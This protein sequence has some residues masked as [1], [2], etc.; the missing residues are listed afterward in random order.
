MEQGLAQVLLLLGAAIASFLVCQRLRIP[1]SLAY[2]AVGVL[3]GPATLGPVVDGEAIRLFA[4]F[5]IV[6][7][8]FT[9]GLNYSLPQLQALRG[10]VLWLGTAQVGLTTLIVGAL[11]W[12][13][14]ADVVAAF[15]IGAIFAQSSTTMISKQLSEQAEENSPHGRLG[16]A[17]SVFQDVTAVPFIVVIPVLGTAVGAAAIAGLIGTSL[18]KAAVAMLLVFFVGRWLLRPLFRIVARQRSAEA[19]TLTV[20]FVSLGAG[21]VTDMLGLSLA[22][23][24][25]LAGMVLGETEFRHQVEA[26]IRPF[27]DVLLGLFFIGIGMLFDPAALPAVWAWAVAGTIVLLAS[28]TLLV[29]GLVRRAGLPIESAWRTGLI[30]SVG[31]EF[32]LALLAIGIASGALDGFKAQVAFTAVLF[33]FIL[34]PLLIRFSSPIA[35]ALTPRRLENAAEAPVVRVEAGHLEQ[36]VIICGYGRI[37]QSV[38]H[39]L[40]QQGIAWGAMDLDLAKVRQARKAGEPVF[41]GDA[42][43]P[44]MLESMGLD[45]ARLVVVSNDDTQASLRVLAHV[46]SRHPG[47]P[48]MVRTRDDS[49]H[50]ALL[51]GGATEV[52][53]ETL[54]AGLMI[55]T[56]VLDR[57]DVAPSRII[58]LVERQRAAHYP[59]LRARFAGEVDAVDHTEQLEPVSLPRGCQSCGKTLREL[60]LDDGTATAIVR[61]GERLLDPAADTVLAEG[62]TVVLRGP[63][64][65]VARASSRLQGR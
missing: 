19:F 25:F 37:G 55:A 36:H 22:F 14:G 11:A 48:V 45:R 57:L 59:L 51:A 5:G 31:G 15:V 3:L 26:T 63:E 52:V 13:A 47:L 61:H 7:L 54:E 9:I 46:R 40:E 17:M 56:H 30:V 27:R 49:H 33:S 23:G 65:V 38:G 44:A 16:T 20:L 24:A 64:D 32:G 10:Q 39:L 42:S 6:F 12:L 4:E 2:L 58:E 50:E 18:A 29:A 21:A 35:R 41:Y 43:D 8:L 60:G 62:D 34:G 28:K 1:T 53:P